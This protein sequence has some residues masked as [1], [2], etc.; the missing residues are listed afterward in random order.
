M[1][2]DVAARFL[3]ERFQRSPWFTTVLVS[4]RNCLPTLLLYVGTLQFREASLFS[5]EWQ[6]YRVELR[7]FPQRAP[8]RLA[9]SLTP[10]GRTADRS[11]DADQATAPE[12]DV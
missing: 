11:F 9:E 10:R 8:K 2:P 1:T 6:G 4:D 12:L 5:A 3:R 7:Q